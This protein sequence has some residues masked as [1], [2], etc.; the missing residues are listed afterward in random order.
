[1][2]KPIAVRTSLRTRLLRTM[3]VNIFRLVLVWV[4]CV[5]VLIT[6]SPQPASHVTAGG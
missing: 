5:G 2:K 1:M 4:C 3:L 6:C